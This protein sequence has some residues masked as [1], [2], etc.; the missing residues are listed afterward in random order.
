[1]FFMIFSPFFLKKTG[2]FTKNSIFQIY[3]EAK[4]TFT[5]ILVIFST[6]IDLQKYRLI[7][8]SWK[9][10]YTHSIA[11]QKVEYRYFCVDLTGLSQGLCDQLF[12]NGPENTLFSGMPAN[13]WSILKGFLKL[14]GAKSECDPLYV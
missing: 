10:K 1:M 3:T 13:F 4:P 7:N 9:P 2:K 12:E 5:F 14:I 6:F 11:L 8:F